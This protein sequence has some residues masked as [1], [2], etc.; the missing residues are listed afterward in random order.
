MILV[1]EILELLN[2]FYPVNLIKVESVTNEMFRCTSDEGYY[3]ARIT[4]YKSFDEQLEEVNYT[5]FLHKEG[6]GVSPTISSLNGNVVEKITLGHKEILTVLYKPVPGVHLQRNQWNANVLKELGRQIG[7]LHR[8]SKKYER[9]HRVRYINDWHDN[10]EYAFLKYIPKEE[11]AIRDL[12]KDVLLTI[13][14]IPKNDTNYGLLHGDLWLENIL[15]DN[16]FNLGMVDFQ[17]CEK[18]FYIFDLAVPIY[19]ALE[20]SF[21]GGGSIVEYGRQITKAII[22]GYLEENDISSEML[23]RLPLFIKLKE[24]FEYSLMHM[25]WNKEKL[26]EEQI[27]IM[28]HYRMRLEQNHSIPIT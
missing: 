12:A 3:F 18:H 2:K 11:V 26:T 4:N 19:S 9:I 16:D 14:N 17:D 22:E 21:V 25:Y 1:Q 10:E 24:I 8:L 27:R 23:E 7:K 13:K 28:N 6:L 15:V 20:Y 5:N